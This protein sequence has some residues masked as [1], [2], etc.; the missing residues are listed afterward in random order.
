MAVMTREEF[1]DLTRNYWMIKTNAGV[2]LMF[3]AALGL[4]VGAVITGR[5]SIRQ[6]SRRNGNSRCSAP[7]SAPSTDGG[8]GCN[9]VVLGG[10][11]GRGARL[12]DLHGA[13]TGR[14]VPGHRGAVTHVAYPDGWCFRRGYCRHRRFGRPA[15]LRSAEPELLLR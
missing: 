12:S 4:V 9:P 10:R 15:S 5:H 2:I 14:A 1:A 3:I 6:R 11:R 7:W 8:D 13:V